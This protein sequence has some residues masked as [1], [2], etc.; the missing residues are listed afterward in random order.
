[1][2]AFLNREI[3]FVEIPK[4]IEHTIAETEGRHPESI[5]EVLA[6]DVQARESARRKLSHQLTR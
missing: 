6:I 3:A 1:V 4:V 5:E 2:G